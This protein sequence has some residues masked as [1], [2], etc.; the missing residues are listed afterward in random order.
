M[1]T[2]TLHKKDILSQKETATSKI[3]FTKDRIYK[4]KKDVLLLP[5]I[6]Y[7]SKEKRYINILKEYSK[8]VTYSPQIYIDLIILDAPDI[9]SE[10]SICMCRGKQSTCTL[11]DYIMINGNTQ[12][13]LQKLLYKIK[14][15]HLSTKCVLP[16]E[17][18]IMNVGQRFA[19][20]CE[21]AAILNVK[22]EDSYLKLIKSYITYYDSKYRERCKRKYIRE[23]HGDLHSGNILYDGKEY[24]FFDFLDFDDSYTNGDYLNDLGFLLADMYFFNVMNIESSAIEKVADFFNDE[25]VLILL[26]CA[27]GALNRANVFLNCNRT[28]ADKFYDLFYMFLQKGIKYL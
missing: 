14:Q 27:Y 9:H 2:I 19:M 4:V 25:P 3:L 20:L 22:L 28:M 13:D 5:F 7:S 26:F 11:F 21:E 23:L 6:D 1:D 12:L 8:G 15:F 24:F 16:S 10:P 17:Q 18:S